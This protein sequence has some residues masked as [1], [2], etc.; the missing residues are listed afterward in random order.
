VPAGGRAAHRRL[1]ARPSGAVVRAAAG[2]RRRGGV[3]LP[4]PRRTLPLARVRLV[5]G[6]QPLLD[7][8]GRAA[9]LHHDPDHGAVG[10]RR[11]RPAAGPPPG[12]TVSASTRRATRPS[13]GQGR[14]DRA[15]AVVAAVVVAVVVVALVA[16]LIAG[17]GDD[18]GVDTATSPRD[19][20]PSDEGPSDEGTRFTDAAVPDDTPAT[21]DGEPLPPLTDD[22]DDPAI[23]RPMPT[24]SGTGL[25]G[26]PRRPVTDDGGDPAIG[27]PRPPLGGPGLDGRPLTLPAAGRPAI[28]VFLAHWCPHCQAEVPVIQ[29]WVDSGGLPDG[30]DLFGVSTAVDPRR[31]NHPPARWL[32]AEGWTSPVL[33]DG[34]QAAAQAVGLTAY[35]FFV[36]VDADGEVVARGSGELSAAQLTALAEMTAGGAS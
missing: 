23:G 31:P 14:P 16:A 9:G 13:P 32:D 35:P 34:D 7:R 11:R 20:A 27:G 6:D 10:V 36:A 29:D 26:R 1:A 28:V 19:T 21:V 17:S 25:D 2:G 33:V 22:G 30:V 5:R 8:L 15:V 3:D 12:D 18:D 4:H 24:L